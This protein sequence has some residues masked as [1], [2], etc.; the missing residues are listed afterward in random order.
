MEII[1]NPPINASLQA[2]VREFGNSLIVDSSLFLKNENFEENIDKVISK[3]EQYCSR[4][5]EIEIKN[6]NQEN[7]D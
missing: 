6:L 1:E 4:L 2:L 5:R 3:M 7:S